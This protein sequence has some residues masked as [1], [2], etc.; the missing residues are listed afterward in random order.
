MENSMEWQPIETAP[1]DKSILLGCDYDRYG[2]QRVTLG[3]W[4]ERYSESSVSGK[5]IEGE[6]FDF[7]ECEWSPMRV[8]F[9]PTHWAP[10]PAPPE[11]GLQAAQH[12]AEMGRAA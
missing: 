8:E 1:K 11:K 10:L 4:A 7:D 12:A 2:K 6:A 9:R 5:W 3:W